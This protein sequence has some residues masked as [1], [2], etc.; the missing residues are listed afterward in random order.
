MNI[1]FTTRCARANF[2]VSRRASLNKRNW[3][4]V[5]IASESSFLLTISTPNQALCQQ[6]CPE[7]MGHR[8]FHLT[9]DF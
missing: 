1:F 3:F 6:G 4:G 2:G 7:T 5:E 9:S 8:L